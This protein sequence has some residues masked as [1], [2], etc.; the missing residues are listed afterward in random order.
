M[1]FCF[2]FLNFDHISQ[3]TTAF[4]LKLVRFRF[5]HLQPE[6]LAILKNLCTSIYPTS[7]QTSQ[8]FSMNMITELFYKI[9]NYFV[10][11]I[12]TFKFVF[13]AN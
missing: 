8:E 1:V 9:K 10:N 12:F 3:K 7:P 11:K 4:L 5:Y 2:F 13:Y 6:S